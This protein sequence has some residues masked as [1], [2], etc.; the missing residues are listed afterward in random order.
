MRIRI[1]KDQTSASSG[2]KE[3]KA[4]MEELA[5]T[6]DSLSVDDCKS[7][8]DREDGPLEKSDDDEIAGGSE[9]S[10]Q[11]LDGHRRRLD[12]TGTGW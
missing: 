7:A 9:S 1:A 6:G 5:M 12:R 3:E 4:G 2:A 10:G 8:D 11:R